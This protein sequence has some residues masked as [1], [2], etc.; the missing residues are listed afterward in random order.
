MGADEKVEDYA[1]WLGDAVLKPISFGNDDYIAD[2]DAV[3]ITSLME[4]KNLSYGEAVNVY[5]KEIE[6]GTNRADVFLT[7]KDLSIVKEDIYKELAYPQIDQERYVA[8]LNKDKDEIRIRR[9]NS[10]CMIDF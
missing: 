1:G 7:N 10:F 2:L 6:E 3:N 9:R 5:Y 4:S 8:R